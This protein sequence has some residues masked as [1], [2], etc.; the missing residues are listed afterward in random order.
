MKNNSIKHLIFDLGGVIVDLD[1][2]KT[3]TEMSE[4]FG[5]DQQQLT[6]QY[7]QAPFFK[8]YE[9]GEIN[10][11]EFRIELCRLANK[12]VEKHRIDHAWNAMIG[13]TPMFRINWLKE[14]RKSYKI[15][16]LSNTNHLHIVDFHEKFQK[17]TGIE[18]PHDIFDSI[19]YSYEIGHRKPEVK[20]YQYVLDSIDAKPDEVMFFDDNQENIKAAQSIG[21]NSVL[22]PVNKLSKELLPDVEI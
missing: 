14:L 9:R 19:F 20:C 11:E 6:A 2:M 22:V 15:H 5:V 21:I 18:K 1:V 4:L 12:E 13:N 10:S 3:L 7:L 8:H 16:M 17:D